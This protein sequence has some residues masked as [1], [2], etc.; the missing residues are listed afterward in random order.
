MCVPMWTWTTLGEA[1]VGVKVGSVLTHT[2][3]LTLIATV[4][5]V[6]TV[7]V[8]GIARRRVSARVSEEGEE[9]C[10]SGN[11]SEEVHASEHPP[12]TPPLTHSITYSTYTHTSTQIIWLAYTI[13]VLIIVAIFFMMISH[14]PLGEQTVI[15]WVTTPSLRTHHTRSI[16]TPSEELQCSPPTMTSL[17]GAYYNSNTVHTVSH[18]RGEYFTS[19]VTQ[20]LFDQGLL[21]LHGFNQFEAI[22][23]FEAAL[24]TDPLCYLCYWGIAQSS[25]TNLNNRMRETMYLKGKWSITE[26]LAIYNKLNRTAVNTS[27]VVF[28]SKLMKML[29]SATALS[30]GTAP[31]M[32]FSELDVDDAEAQYSMALRNIYHLLET[33]ESDILNEGGGFSGFGF[34]ADVGIFLAESLLNLTPWKYYDVVAEGITAQY[35]DG[36][37]YEVAMKSSHFNSLAQE[38]FEIF[39][40]VLCSRQEPHTSTPQT[41]AEVNKVARCNHPLGLHLYIHLV[42][43]MDNPQL[44][45]PEAMLLASMSF[46][47]C[48]LFAANFMQILAASYNI[49]QIYIILYS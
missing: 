40:S 38:A 26:A 22:R 30:F 39:Q 33:Q 42:E 20:Q 44:G 36:V 4:V 46:F 19:L 47:N 37:R 24:A 2:L 8:A 17:I 21:L 23:N 27:P 13:L 5:V 15:K 18:L 31:E 41:E 34:A 35:T 49:A 6:V 45:I 11:G 7:M 14:N 43:Q 32:S 48:H 9:E 28:E 1:G 29:L 12:S 25:R 10:S 16:I 3:T